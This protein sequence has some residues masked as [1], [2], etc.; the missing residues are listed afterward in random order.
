MHLIIF[1]SSKNA[2]IMKNK[3]KVSFFLLSTPAAKIYTAD[4]ADTNLIPLPRK[5]GDNKEKAQSAD[6]FFVCLFN[7]TDCI[8]MLFSTLILLSLTFC[9]YICS[10]HLDSHST[11]VIVMGFHTDIVSRVLL[12]I[13]SVIQFIYFKDLFMLFHTYF[14]PYWG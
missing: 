12:P 14:C 11:P 10:Y 6:S 8:K 7:Y 3:T 9:A 4:R 5:C 1:F 13:S 2:C